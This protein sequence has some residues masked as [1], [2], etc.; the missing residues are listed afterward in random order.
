[1][2]SCAFFNPS[3][4]L[5]QAAISDISQCTGVVL[6]SGAEY[7][8]VMSSRT[9][10]TNSADA[11]SIASAFIGLLAIAYCYRALSQVITQS[12][13]GDSNETH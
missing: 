13:E 12:Y 11:G 4:Q 8:D 1:M 3:G 9:L 7:A 2:A 5:I 10:I 6:M